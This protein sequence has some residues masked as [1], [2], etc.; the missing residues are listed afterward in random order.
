M[1]AQL[2]EMGW[3]SLREKIPVLVGQQRSCV[4]PEGRRETPRRPAVLLN[5]EKKA[6]LEAECRVQRASSL[7]FEDSHSRP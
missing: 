5:G 2:L 1:P 4:A 6:L 3:V 7:Y